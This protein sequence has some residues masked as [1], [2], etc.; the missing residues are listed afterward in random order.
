MIKIDK[1]YTEYFDGSD[2]K[3]P[4]G[5]AINAPDGD[6]LEGTAWNAEWFNT[7]LGFFQAVIVKAHNTFKVSGTPDNIEKSDILDALIEIMKVTV[8]PE[9]DKRITAN[10]NNIKTNAGKIADIILDLTRVLE[11]IPH[12][13]SD[14]PDN[15]RM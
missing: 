10:T 1:N 2:K 7:I 4:G 6:S 15:D 5:K 14:A 8:N 3:Y 12:L 11:T 9:M 13:V